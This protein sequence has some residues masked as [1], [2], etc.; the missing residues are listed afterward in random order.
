MFSNSLLRGAGRKVGKVIFAVLV[1]HYFHR[2]KHDVE[3]SDCLKDDDIL[4]HE[5]FTIIKV[6]YPSVGRS[7]F[8]LLFEGYFESCNIVSTS[9][10]TL[11]CIKN[12]SMQ[13]YH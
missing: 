12:L 4:Y 10:Y 1:E 5:A 2:S 11:A 9:P 3:K 6:S 13:A 8:D 7:F